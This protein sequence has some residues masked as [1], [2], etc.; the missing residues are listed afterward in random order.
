ME[1]QTAPKGA[2]FVGMEGDRAV[3]RVA[4]GSYGFTAPDVQPGA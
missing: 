2:T 4:S 1:P 3:Y